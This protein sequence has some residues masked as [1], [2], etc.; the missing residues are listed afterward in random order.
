VAATINAMLRAV[1]GW[2]IRRPMVTVALWLVLVVAGFTAG[3]GVF[4]RLVSDV[5]AVPGSES[6]RAWSLRAC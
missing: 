1:T 6:D 4:G 3:A 2:S 5:G